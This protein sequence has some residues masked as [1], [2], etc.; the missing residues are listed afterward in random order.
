MP[1]LNPGSKFQEVWIAALTK[2]KED[3][4]RDY[5]EGWFGE[6]TPDALFRLLDVDLQGRKKYQKKRTDLRAV[7]LPVLDL[8]IVSSKTIGE[9]LVTVSTRLPLFLRHN[10]TLVITGIPARESGFCRHSSV[11]KGMCSGPHLRMSL[12]AVV[13]LGCK[14]CQCE[15]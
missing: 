9:S 11:A 7:I 14:G 12:N 10:L 15:L 1:N 6:D 13:D 4:E 8:V 5:F 2:Y 3:T